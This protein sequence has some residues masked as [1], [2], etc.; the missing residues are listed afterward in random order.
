MRKIVELKQLRD[1]HANLWII[2]R[3][4]SGMIAKV[5]PPSSTDLYA[6]RM[7]LA[8]A[9]ISHLKTED[10]TLYPALL[11]SADERIAMTSRVFS[12]DMGGLAEAF[13][14]YTNRWDAASIQGDWRGYGLETAEILKLLKL[15][16]AREERD[17]YPLLEAT[18]RAAA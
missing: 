14:N 10:W 12:I 8:S 16:M 3:R 15:R 6:V 11:D 13:R 2:V 18:K 7:K 5:L 4:L 17:L 1:E 9:I